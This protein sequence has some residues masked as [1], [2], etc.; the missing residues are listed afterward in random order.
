MFV[1]RLPHVSPQD[2]TDPDQFYWALVVTSLIEIYAAMLSIS[3]PTNSFGDACCLSFCWWQMTFGH[4]DSTPILSHRVGWVLNVSPALMSDLMLWDTYVMN[5]GATLL[6]MMDLALLFRKLT[7]WGELL[8]G[9]RLSVAM[10]L[11]CRMMPFSRLE[12]VNDCGAAL[13]VV[14]IMHVLMNKDT[15]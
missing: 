15:F 1:L 11:P 4:P 10:S 8:L 3:M 6:V 5:T 9:E 7:I 2:G 14:P 12:E 13:A